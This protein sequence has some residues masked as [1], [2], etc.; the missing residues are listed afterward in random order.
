M[1]PFL[2][3]SNSIFWLRTHRPWMDCI[4]CVLLY[5]YNCHYKKRGKRKTCIE[6]HTCTCA[7]DFL[8]KRFILLL[9][10]LPPSNNGRRIYREDRSQARHLSVLTAG[11]PWST[12]LRSLALAKKNIEIILEGESIC[13][14]C[15]KSP[16]KNPIYSRMQRVSFWSPANAQILLRTLFWV[17]VHDDESSPFILN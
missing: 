7:A 16:K 10:P 3:R 8:L 15:W 1:L 2:L 5:L 17:A 4:F 12:Y 9:P 6:E 11:S 14:L 13:R